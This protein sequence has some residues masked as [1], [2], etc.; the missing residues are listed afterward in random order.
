MTEAH[1]KVIKLIQFGITF[2]FME[3]LNEGIKNFFTEN[4]IL[5]E[6]SGH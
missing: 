4:F 1:T 5:Y 6:K 2:I 3:S